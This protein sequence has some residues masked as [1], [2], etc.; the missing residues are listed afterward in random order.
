[1]NNA[2]F[3]Q[4][5]HVCCVYWYLLDTHVLYKIH[6]RAQ[7]IVRA[8]YQLEFSRRLRLGIARK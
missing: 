4:N 6:L 5:P 8:V 7:V 1:M 3:V 2:H